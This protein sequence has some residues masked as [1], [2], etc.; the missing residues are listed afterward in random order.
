MDYSV[1]TVLEDEDFTQR[2]WF[3]STPIIYFYLDVTLNFSIKFRVFEVNDSILLKKS[4]VLNTFRVR[5]R[6]NKEPL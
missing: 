4:F 2:K 1:Q 5:N 3:N 6:Q